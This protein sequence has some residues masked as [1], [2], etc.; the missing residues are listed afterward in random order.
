MIYPLALI[1]ALYRRAFRP[2]P[3]PRPVFFIETSNR[4]GFTHD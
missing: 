1:A 4:K 3:T 2:A